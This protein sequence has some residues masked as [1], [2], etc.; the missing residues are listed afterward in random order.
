[1]RGGPNPDGA[2]KLV[3]Y[4][5]S[6]SCER[7]LFASDSH[8]IP[9]RAALRKELLANPAKSG[10]WE[11]SPDPAAPDFAAIESALEASGRDVSEILIR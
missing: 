5:A 2:K 10:A 8:N 3:D 1:V 11:A 9:V 6:A 4:L 7:T